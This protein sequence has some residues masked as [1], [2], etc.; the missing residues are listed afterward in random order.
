MTPNVIYTNGVIAA[1]DKYLLKDKILRFCEL[2]A[3]EAFRMLIESGFGGGAET[4]ENVYEYEKLIEAEEKA[5]DDFILEYAPS[6]E[7]RAYLLSPRDFHNAKALIKAAYL[8]TD[9]EKMLAPQGEIAIEKLSSC[10]QNGDF[11]EFAKEYP[12]LKK[13][14]EDGLKALEADEVLGAELSE[15]FEKAA[16]RQAARVCKRNGVLKHLLQTKADMTNILIAFRSKDE[17]SAKNKYLPGGT[18]GEKTLSM[19]FSDSE[20]A[21]EAFAKTAYRD[22]VKTCF[23]AKQK[24]LPLSAAEKIRDGY[25][26]AY[27]QQRRYDLK[28]NQPFLYYVFR[29][30]TENANVRIVFVCLLAGLKETDVKKRLRAAF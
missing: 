11:S 6:K 25:E 29:R 1:R 10:I 5:V 2:S 24:G 21:E 13:A 14:C 15:I 4:A 3:E 23:E 9:A 30:R 16:Y 27:F 22:F 18:L 8:K 28:K 17:E 26:T 7:E 19:L 20:K 12:E